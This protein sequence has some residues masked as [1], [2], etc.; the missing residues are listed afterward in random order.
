MLDGPQLGTTSYYYDDNGNLSQILPPGVD[1]NE[2]GDQRYYYNQRN[3]LIT[4]TVRGDSGWDDQATFVYDGMGNRVQQV[5]LTGST[6]VTTTYAN[7]NLGLSQVLVAYS[8]NEETSNLFGLDLI[9]QDTRAAI[10]TLLTDGLGSV[11]LEMVEDTIK[12][13]T[14]YDPYGNQLIQTGTNN[15]AYGF[16]GEQE[17]SST[18][19]L[20]LR[21][22][23]YNPYLNQFQSR[24]PF[25]G[26]AK[27]PA[28]Q[29]GYS[30]AH[31]NPINYTDP[32]GK[33][34][35]W[36]S[37]NGGCSSSNNNSTSCEQFVAEVQQIIDMVK[38]MRQCNNI[39]KIMDEG[40]LVLDILAAHYSGIP[41]T[42]EVLGITLYTGFIPQESTFQ[43]GD[44]D[45]WSVPPVPWNADAR[46]DWQHPIND[47]DSDIGQSIRQSYGFKRPYFEQTHHYFAFL[48]FAYRLP[49]LVVWEYHRQAEISHQLKPAYADWQANIGQPRERDYEQYYAWVYQESVYDLL[50]MSQAIE[51][52]EAIHDHGIDILPTRLSNWCAK[53]EADVW[54]L[55]NTANSYYFDFPKKYRPLEGFWP[56]G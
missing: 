40:A 14:T 37:A 21:A 43:P 7:D 39:L 24:D 48:K 13:A 32:S 47:R 11:R 53:D 36:E 33:M 49:D 8:G 17:D 22:R 34:V 3:L 31:N 56:G 54:S 30:Y 10:L 52:A 27:L 6:P 19:L 20:Y 2:A 29:N 1:P 26:Y 55:E 35:A 38:K 23:Y 25:P 28:S 4:S 51:D 9:L 50:I 45:K 15:T 44:P 12:T 16:T 18:G 42:D 41:V 5:D 46:F